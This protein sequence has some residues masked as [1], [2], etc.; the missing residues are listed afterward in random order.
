M[1]ISTDQAIARFERKAQELRDSGNW[2][3][4]HE[5]QQRASEMRRLANM[6]ASLPRA[7]TQPAPNGAIR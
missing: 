7:R 3:V 6:A 4:S 1:G 2:T 5:W